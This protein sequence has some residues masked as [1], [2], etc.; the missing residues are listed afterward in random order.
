M[1]RVWE[2]GSG[3]TLA[4]GTGACAAVVV[5]IQLGK[6]KREPVLVHL[7]GG[8]LTIDWK[9]DNY[10]YKRGPSMFVT[11]GVYFYEINEKY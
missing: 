4:C 5:G 10:V 3:E 6:L 9:A 7:K 2:R 11:Q 1:C 8:D